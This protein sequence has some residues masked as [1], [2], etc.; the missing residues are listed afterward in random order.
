MVY[1]ILKEYGVKGGRMDQHFL[2]DAAVLDEI[3]DAAQLEPSDIV[4][5]IGGGIGNLSERIAPR[6]SELIIIELDPQMVRILKSRLSVYENIKIISGNVM[7][8]DLSELPFN[9]IVANLPYSISSDVTLK[10]LQRDFDRAVLMYQYEFARRL[11]AEPGGKEYGRLSVHV[12]YKTD[13]SMIL[14]VPKSAFEPAPKVDSAVISLIPRQVSYPVDD[15]SFFFEVTKALFSQRRKKIKNTLLGSSLN[16]S[17]PNLKE[18]LERLSGQ[19][20]AADGVSVPLLE[21]T[22]GDILS[23]RAEELSPADIARFSNLLYRQNG[24]IGPDSLFQD[25]RYSKNP[26]EGTDSHES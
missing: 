13:A 24:A 17:M 21:K 9:K 22:A 4:L 6:V 23:M 8:V 20:F 2:T 14:K 11:T 16:A 25:A 18:L 12:R 10:F 26:N 7:D 5:E 19:P 3:I 1:Q 15:K